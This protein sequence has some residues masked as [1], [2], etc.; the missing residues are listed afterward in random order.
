M[1]VAKCG[2]GN[3]IGSEDLYSSSFVAHRSGSFSA[4]IL[5]FYIFYL[6]RNRTAKHHRSSLLQRRLV[7]FRC[8]FPWS[9]HVSAV[10]LLIWFVA[11]SMAVAEMDH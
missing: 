2:G 11:L 6:E 10:V 7:W 5:L 4:F 3:A 1:F 8:R 9:D